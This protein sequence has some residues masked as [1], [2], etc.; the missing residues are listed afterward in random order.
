M[1]RFRICEER[2]SG[3][4]KVVHEVEFYQLPA[5]LFEEPDGFTRTAAP[6]NMKYI[7]WW[8]SP[9]EGV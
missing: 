4:D 6:K 5:P 7:P 2:G 8:T 3:I 1:R 9:K